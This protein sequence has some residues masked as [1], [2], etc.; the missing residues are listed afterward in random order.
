[1][2]YGRSWKRIAGG[3][4]QNHFVRVVREDPERRGLPVRRHGARPFRILR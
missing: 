1:M 2:T 3:L 4:P